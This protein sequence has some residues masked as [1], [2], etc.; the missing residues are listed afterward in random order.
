MRVNNV[1]IA[2][3]ERLAKVKDK[4]DLQVGHISL[5]TCQGHSTHDAPSE[6]KTLKSS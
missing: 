6:L 3:L 5:E 2:R 1:E 4:A